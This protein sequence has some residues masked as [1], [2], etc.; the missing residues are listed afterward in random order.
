MIQSSHA[1][2]IPAA[3]RLWNSEISEFLACL[4]LLVEDQ[5]DAK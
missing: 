1:L 3:C 2:A 4:L 5:L